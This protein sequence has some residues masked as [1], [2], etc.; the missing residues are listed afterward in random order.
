MCYILNFFLYRLGPC[1]TN[2]V[3]HASLQQHF[4]VLKTKAIAV[5][6]TITT[7]AETR[8]KDKN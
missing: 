7:T 1:S 5:A 8:E 3:K 6:T 2:T 4:C